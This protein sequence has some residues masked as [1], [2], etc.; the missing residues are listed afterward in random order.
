MAIFSAPK[1]FHPDT[2]FPGQFAFSQDLHA[3]LVYTFLIS[4]SM[5]LICFS[6]LAKKIES[7]FNS[8]ACIAVS[9][10]LM[11]V[12]TGMLFFSFIGIPLV[13]IA[14]IFMG[15]STASIVIL[16]GTVYSSFDFATCVLNAGAAFAFGFIGAD[17]LTNWVPAPISGI[18]ACIMPI[19]I[20]AA[21]LRGGF[22]MRAQTNG[23]IP[24]R[25]V[26]QYITRLGISMAFLG[27]VVG[28]LR[29]VCGDKLL[30][31]GDITMELVLGVGCMV[32]AAVMIFAIALSKRSELWDSLLRNVTPAIMLGIAGIAFLA[33]DARIFA[34]FFTVIGFACL[35]SMTWILLASFA[36][37]LNGSHI[38]VFG[39]GYGIVQ[40]AS[41]IG[42]G[43]AN[44]LSS[45][46]L[47]GAS[48][49][50]SPS[51]EIV[52]LTSEVGL[53][54]LAIVLMVVLSAA[55]SI[56]PRYRE[57]KE[58]LASLMIA[59][60]KEL[61]SKDAVKSESK[62]KAQ[63]TVVPEQENEPSS[64][65]ED[66]SSSSS[67]SV[68]NAK[69]VLHKGGQSLESGQDN[70][71]I[72]D[73]KDGAR[74]Q[75]R[76]KKGSFIRRCDEIS[77]QYKLSVRETEAFFLLAKGHNAAFLMEQLC[78]SRS[79]AKTHIN[80]IY[81]KLGIH[82]QQELLNMVEDRKRG[83]ALGNVDRAALQDALRR[84]N[85]EG[86]LERDPSKLVEHI[87]QDIR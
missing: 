48:F 40:L 13:L 38:F 41:I 53:S 18:C 85:E 47:L 39:F 61:A 21:M 44:Y 49:G 80:H 86:P 5:L 72:G 50:N 17:A 24:L 30:S 78:I 31:S 3:L 62:V 69:G 67:D 84:A 73:T 33:G 57:L 81:K 83:P 7:F 34:A 19:L 42:V 59:L 70:E 27:L 51:M 20:F 15:A 12:G 43:M 10:L 37:H 64:S 63:A 46:G 11:F 25:Y 58:I 23:E 26:R 2:L 76:D 9:C 28:A 4:S 29:V 45:Q 68:D 6:I 56:M 14:S 36:H 71:T 55:Y 1:T 79:T 60:S 77:E 74:R 16:L 75:S 22:S 35:V 8:K 52:G 82:T 65:T 87:R 66:A 32:S 54:D